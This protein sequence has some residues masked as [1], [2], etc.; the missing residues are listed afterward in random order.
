MFFDTHTKL[1]IE[2][3][4][5]DEQL[6]TLAG[7]ARTKVLYRGKDVKEAR[8]VYTETQKHYQDRAE[9]ERGNVD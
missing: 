8:K 5:G 7:D 9:A 6:V 4:Q 1:R 2:W 3:K